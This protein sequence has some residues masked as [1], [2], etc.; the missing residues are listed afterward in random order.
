MA[1]ES[2]TQG[3]GGYE[4]IAVAVAAYPAADFQDVGDDD[5]G[6]GRLKLAFHTAIKF[7]QRLKKAHREDGYAVVDFVVNA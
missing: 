4:W 5:V 7:R 3:F 1:A 2:E 6:L